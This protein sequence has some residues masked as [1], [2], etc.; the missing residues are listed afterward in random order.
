MV[1]FILVLSLFVKKLL[2]RF[3]FPPIVVVGTSEDKEV[4]FSS[5]LNIHYSVFI[6]GID[7]SM[8]LNICT[9]WLL[10]RRIV[11]TWYYSF[12]ILLVFSYL[13]LIIASVIHF[14]ESL[15]KY[16]LYFNFFIYFNV[17]YFRNLVRSLNVFLFPT[18]SCPVIKRKKVLERNIKNIKN[19]QKLLSNFFYLFLYSVFK[20]SWFI[21]ILI[22]LM[23]SQQSK[24]TFF[25]SMGLQQNTGFFQ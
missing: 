8:I 12:P 4:L 10:V 3:I 2:S 25:K 14:S 18:N 6:I 16:Q 11:R 7:L 21:S 20:L 24:W 5:S 13:F 22:W 15:K 17:L 19:V 9:N 23:F 1:S